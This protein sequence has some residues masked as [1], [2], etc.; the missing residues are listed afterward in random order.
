MTTEQEQKIEKHDLFFAKLYN[1][2]KIPEKEDENAGL[3]VYAH[4]EQETLT[5]RP[6]ETIKIPTGIISAFTK[7]WVVIFKERGST[8]TKGIAQRSGVIDSGYRGEW[9]VPITNTSK[10]RLII[11]KNKN[12]LTDEYKNNHK[13]LIIYDYNKAICQAVV[14]SVPKMKIQEKTVEEIKLI[15]SKRGEG[16]LGSSGK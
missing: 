3:D 7:D 15:S 13:N 1:D 11:T 14:L 10:K 4:F 2:V 6:H 12:L 9:L 8:G 5:I 16:K